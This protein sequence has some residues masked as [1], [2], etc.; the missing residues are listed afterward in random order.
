M[1]RFQA[2]VGVPT[3]TGAA[4][5]FDKSNAAFD[6]PTGEQQVGSVNRSRRIVNAVKFLG[7]FRF[8]AQLNRLGPRRLHAIRQFV[9]ARA[10]SSS[11]SSCLSRPNRSLMDCRNSSLL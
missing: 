5:T 9:R 4:I 6:Q 3:R 10:A 11:V 8:G 7:G 1:I 2:A